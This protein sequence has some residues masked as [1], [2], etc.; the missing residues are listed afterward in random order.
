MSES[1]E[2]KLK[3]F[4]VFCLASG[5]MV[6]SGIFILPGLAH[7]AAGPAV[8]LSYLLAGL[9]ACTGMLSVAEI[10]TAMPR[11]GGDYFFIGR[12]LGPAVGA[13]AGLLSWFSLTLKSAFALVGLSAFLTPLIGIDARILGVLLSFVFIGINLMGTSHAARLQR[14]LVIGLLILMAVYII[15]GIGRMEMERLVPFAPTGWYGILST[16]GL[17]FV[18]YGG[19]LN[20]ASVAEEV[21]NPGRTIPKGLF[22]SLLVIV[23]F[24]T[25]MVFITSGI[26]GASE[27]DNSLT[28]IS[29]GAMVI[30]GR[31]GFVLM[32][33]AA[34]FAFISTANAGLLA[35]SRYLVALA[36]D[37][38]MPGGLARVNERFG[39]PHPAVL[40]TG[41]LMIV[42]LVLPLDLLVKAASTVL[43]STYCLAN[44]CVIVL[45]ESRLENYRPRFRAPLYPWLQAVG[46][47]GF[48]LLIVEMGGQALLI[49]LFLVLGG[50]AFYWVYG[51]V[52]AQREY[53]LLHLLERFIDKPV[54]DDGLETEL[55]NI[56]RERE[57]FCL[58]HF[59]KAV[60]RAE[61]L[62]L[63]TELN[64][65]QTV[66]MLTSAVQRHTGLSND[67]AQKLMADQ[68][69]KIAFLVPGLAV[70]DVPIPELENRLELV[71]VRP[72]QALSLGTKTVSGLVLIIRDQDY[73]HHFLPAAAALAQVALAAD[74][75]DRWEKAK[76]PDRL[77][78][79][80]LTGHRTRECMVQPQ[81]SP[82]DNTS[83]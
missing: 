31:T 48:V 46:A 49:S 59:D 28:P 75:W 42:A 70:V 20:V 60:E 11:A 71:L 81:E 45:R 67:Q 7:A 47:V 77:R 4:D 3:Y 43:L 22:S 54:P 63:P 53:A 56:I 78:D 55:K 32:S 29:D 8:V 6:S 57:Q 24:Y 23:V 36:R 16:A 44:I 9:L 21:D 1:L 26:L 40:I 10:I 12:T 64:L 74:F 68:L 13:S 30:A 17:V 76:N 66:E 27:L 18:S 33:L 79:L 83:G 50:L 82:P 19:L 41:A 73:D 38:L 25:L 5:A 61:V 65:D 2:K 58:D 35:A 80:L 51:R 15:S 39:T 34:S 62:E 14:W 72:D 52:R 37:R 69:E